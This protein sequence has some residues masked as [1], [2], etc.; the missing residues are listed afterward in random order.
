MY[1]GST[2]PCKQSKKICC[3]FKTVIKKRK[4]NRNFL[5]SVAFG[6][7]ILSHLSLPIQVSYKK[8]VTYKGK[9]CINTLY[10]LCVIS[11]MM[12]SIGENVQYYGGTSSVLARNIVNNGN[13]PR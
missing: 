7:K 8:G 10:K 2:E 11:A 12:Y 5:N 4:K 9:I 6:L 1:V 3:I 13:L